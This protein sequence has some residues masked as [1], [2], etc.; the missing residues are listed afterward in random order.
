[1]L[2]IKIYDRTR[3][4]LTAFNLGE[5]GGLTYKKTLGQIGDASFNLDINNAKVTE[6]NMRNY[7]RIEILNAGV[8]E[9]SGYIVSKQINFNQVMVQCKGL[10][11]ILARRLTADNYTLSGNAGTAVGTL[12]A[13]INLTEDT[14]IVMGATDIS[15]SINLTFNQQD[16][17]S[18]LQKIADTV[19][20]QF[21][22]NDIDRT[23]DFKTTIGEDVSADVSLEYNIIQPQ[24]ANITNFDVQD[25]GD[26]IVSRSYGKTPTLTS[27]QDDAALKTKYGILEKFNS[28]SE[29]NTQ[30]ILDAL[31]LSKIS[32]TLY[33]P[34]ILL[35]PSDNDDF[36]IGD[37]V[38]VDIQNKL[39][40]IADTF[41]VLEKSVK[42]VNSQKQISVKINQLPQDITKNIRDLQRQVNI[43]ETN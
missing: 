40:N 21:V 43:L 29:A 41:Q 37:L 8:V 19:G 6:V 34:T 28:F 1:M 10:I 14:G 22:V 33:S 15:T 36:D 9:W 3:T 32:D 5:F 16:A 2:Q 11:G 17:F 25:N 35:T 20:G 39:I 30:G 27:M 23:L 12:L 18:V 13:A 24:L 42:I 26:P 31:T 7:N 38:A 4:A